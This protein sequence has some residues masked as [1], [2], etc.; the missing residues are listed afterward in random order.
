MNA[1][2]GANRSANL[3]CNGTQPEMIA[4]SMPHTEAKTNPGNN[5]FKIKLPIRS[6]LPEHFSKIG[7]IYL[8]TN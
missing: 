3:K 2:Y 8:R 7:R 6:T 4:D 5:N 1:Y